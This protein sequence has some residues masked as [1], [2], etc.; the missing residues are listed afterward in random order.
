M[1]ADRSNHS[2]HH[3]PNPYPNATHQS[4]R[5]SAASGVS[6]INKAPVDGLSNVAQDTWSQLPNGATDL[7]VVPTSFDPIH[8]VQSTDSNINVDHQIPLS[9]HVPP[10]QP[11]TFQN[12]SPDMNSGQLQ[13]APT[14]SLGLQPNWNGA[15]GATRAPKIL[16]TNSSFSTT[17]AGGPPINSQALRTLYDHIAPA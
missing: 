8:E 11:H 10:V 13:V 3:D 6:V 2:T 16:I 4:R 9:R 5:V 15:R 7:D 14:V 17:I 12:S 1:P